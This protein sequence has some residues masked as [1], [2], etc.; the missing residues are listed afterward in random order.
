M[1]FVFEIGDKRFYYVRIYFLDFEYSL[2]EIY[3]WWGK[4]F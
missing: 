1:D 2:L 4:K 3:I